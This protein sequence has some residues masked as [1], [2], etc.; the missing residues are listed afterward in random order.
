MHNMAGAFRCLGRLREAES[1]YNK[2]LSIRENRL[3][4]V[5]PDVASTINNLA[6]LMLLMKRSER[7]A[8]LLRRAIKLRAHLLGPNHPEV[9]DSIIVFSEASISNKTP[10]LNVSLLY[11]AARIRGIQ[12]RGTS[13]ETRMIALLNKFREDEELVY[14][15]L[16]PRAMDSRLPNLLL[17]W[18]FL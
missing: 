2:V 5:H 9:A 11:T 7:A 17:E 18:P 12:L 3:G 13:S 14:G 6:R 16:I 8:V 15:M 4:K 1:L 10:T